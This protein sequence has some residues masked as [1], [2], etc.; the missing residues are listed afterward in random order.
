MNK[1]IATAKQQQ[2]K[3]QNL[4]SLLTLDVSVFK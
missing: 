1:K 3:T 2:I 4:F